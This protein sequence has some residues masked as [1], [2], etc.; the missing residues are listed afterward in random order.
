MPDC[1]VIAVANQKGGV[2]KT[3]TT[4]NLG[5]ALARNGKKVLLVDS[6]PQGDLTTYMGYGPNDFELSLSMLF[7]DYISD[8][9][10]LDIKDSI[11]HHD[12]KVDLIPSDIDLSTFEMITQNEMSRET[13][14]KNML[15]NIKDYYDY[16]IID[17]QPSLGLLTVNALSMANS[18][19]IPVQ[20]HYLDEK[21]MH[22]L[23]SSIKKVRERINP[24]L[25]VDGI[26]QTMVSLNTNLFKEMSQRFKDTYGTVFNIYKTQIPR[27]VKAAEST[28]TGK[29]VFEYD[30][31]GKVT[32]AYE[33]LAKEVL[34]NHER[35][36]KK[37][38]RTKEIFSR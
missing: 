16:I 12:E 5:A 14:M 38:T 22:G 29:S 35:E 4:F 34:M 13:L 17:C 23:I 33:E 26:L 21:G 32:K 25:K 7:F 31:N 9:P 15:H 36:R 3:T 2:G 18:V 20:T 1:K 11:L 37:G 24:D 19:I 10:E 8:N 28:F 30:K 27:A 6:D